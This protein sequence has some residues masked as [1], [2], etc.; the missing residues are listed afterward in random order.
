M[1][2]KDV[3][4]AEAQSARPADSLGAAARIMWE[5]DYGCVP[6][7]DESNK[8]VGMLTDRDVCMAAYL[9]GRP[10]SEIRVEEAMARSV[11][12]CGPLTPVDQA[13]AIM[14]EHQVRRLPVTDEGGHLIGLLSINDLAMAGSHAVRADPDPA[15]DPEAIEV[16]LAA[17]SRPRRERRRKP[18][19]A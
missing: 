15:L 5:G 6:I 10:L 8:V 19:L 7:V 12:T 4:T 1:K 13:E 18:G 2:V 14:Q 11:Y 3:M 16:T 9:K 17:V